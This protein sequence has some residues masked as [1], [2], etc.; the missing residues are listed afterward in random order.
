MSQADGVEIRRLGPGDE[1]VAEEACRLF[2]LEGDRD[3][4]AF[5]ARAETAL[6]VASEDS[7]VRD[8]VYGHELVH[9]D[10]ERTMLLYALDVAEGSRRRGIGRALVAALVDH[11][12]RR[13]CTEVWVLTDDDNPA[14]LATYRS[15]GGTR[16][17]GGQVMFTW[18]LAD[19]RHS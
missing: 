5:F 13:D 16:D 17:A 6:V 9:P 11:A 1:S 3:P 2:G 7:A 8:W 18:K 19:G 4:T 12:R 10:G 14:G 15:A